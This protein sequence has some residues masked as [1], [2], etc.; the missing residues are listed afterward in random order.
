MSIPAWEKKES[1]LGIFPALKR[2][3]FEAKEQF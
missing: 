1:V 3:Q 2:F